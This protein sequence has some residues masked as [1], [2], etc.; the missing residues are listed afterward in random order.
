MAWSGATFG[1][2]SQVAN[3]HRLSAIGDLVETNK[4][5][6]DTF[7]AI[8]APIST[9]GFKGFRSFGKGQIKKLFEVKKKKKN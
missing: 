8:L 6:V 2:A 4:H 3:F 9:V 5:V 7:W 1:V